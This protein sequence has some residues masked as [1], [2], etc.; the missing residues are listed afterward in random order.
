VGLTNA[1]LM[2]LKERTRVAMADARVA[3]IAEMAA[4][5]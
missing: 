3:L 2:E 4:N 1:D 5:A